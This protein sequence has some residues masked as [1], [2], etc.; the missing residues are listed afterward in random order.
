MWAARPHGP[1]VLRVFRAARERL[2]LSPLAIHVNYLINLASC[3]PVIR[4]KSI[5]A[6]QGELERAA[7]IGADYVVL[8]P[9]SYKGSTV[10]DALTAL[11]D[12]LA[13]SAKKVRLSGLTIL[14]ENTAGAGC[15]LGS[16]FEEL[17]WIRK[18][19]DLPI[20]YCLDTCH[21]LAAGFD[22]RTP[23]GLAETLAAA[24]SDLGLDNVRLIH[25]NDSKGGLGSRLDR[26]ANIGEGQIGLAAFRR[27]LRH[28]LLREKAFILETPVDQKGDDQRNLDTL[29]SLCRRSSLITP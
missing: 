26:H 3:D 6:F 18:R 2:E 12:G 11:I 7:A 17:R 28:P 22:I 13:L 10:E 21:L 20:G 24:E 5:A 15:Q 19:S 4:A 25:A 23:A 9:G 1:E 14:I 16:R 27:I 29:K 8:H